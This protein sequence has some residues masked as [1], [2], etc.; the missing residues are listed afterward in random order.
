MEIVFSI[1]MGLGLSAACGF[2]I[3]IPLLVAGIGIHAGALHPAPDFTWLGSTPALV[4][5]GTATLLEIAAYYIPWL[6]N[7]L[8]IAATVAVRAGRGRADPRPPRT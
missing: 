3:F 1:L 2:R 8:D 7:V 5:F 6:D 4:G